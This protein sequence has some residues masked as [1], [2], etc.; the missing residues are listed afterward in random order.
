MDCIC[1]YFKK[2]YRKYK[3]SK[4]YD[5]EMDHINDIDH[6]NEIDS[7]IDHPYDN[8]IELIKYNDIQ[9]NCMDLL[10][11]EQS[12]DDLPEQSNSEQHETKQLEEHQPE[13]SNSVHKETGDIKSTLSLVEDV[14][15]NLVDL[16]PINHTIN[17]SVIDQIETDSNG[18]ISDDLYSCSSGEVS[19]CSSN[20]ISGSD[21]STHDNFKSC[22]DNKIFIDN[23]V[24][25]LNQ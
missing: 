18:C 8:D 20:G 9:V 2:I 11:P 3:Y 23:M 7:L 4:S 13:Q 24:N 12:K 14:Q 15:H 16:S 22:I 1:T 5:K 17:I 21:N 25:H 19:P 6:E 10:Q